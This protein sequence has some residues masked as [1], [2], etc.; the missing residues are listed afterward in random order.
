MKT[1]VSPGSFPQV[2]DPNFTAEAQAMLDRLVYH[3]SKEWASSH[4]G[5]VE[6]AAIVTF[7][8]CL[9]RLP[10]L[11]PISRK[12]FFRY[13]CRALQRKMF[14]DYQAAQR[15]F[16]RSMNRLPAADDVVVIMELSSL[17]RAEFIETLHDAV[18]QLPVDQRTV[19]ELRLF[20]QMRF[21]KI[22]ELTEFSPDKV[23]RLYHCARA[24]VREAL[25][26]WV[27]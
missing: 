3:G 19:F 20:D 16:E 18:E 12:R 23:G 11:Y 24:N 13:C 9:K 21:T 6:D 1:N 4:H 22:A 8:S 14:D 26:N 17:E 2:E 5:D 7:H 27:V 15:S 10:R 25:A